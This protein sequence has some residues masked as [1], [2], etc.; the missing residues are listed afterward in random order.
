M[1]LII[2]ILLQ[3]LLSLLKLNKFYKLFMEK[4]LKSFINCSTHVTMSTLAPWFLLSMLWGNQFL[5]LSLMVLDFQLRICTNI[6]CSRVKRNYLNS[7]KRMELLLEQDWVS[8]LNKIFSLWKKE[9]KQNKS[10]KIKGLSK[11]WY[12]RREIRSISLKN[13][14]NYINK[15]MP[16]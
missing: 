4:I 16:L 3:I 12:M 2:L 10:M 9:S 5:K 14:R 7:L 1:L 11:N 15:N 13:L 6:C 8:Q